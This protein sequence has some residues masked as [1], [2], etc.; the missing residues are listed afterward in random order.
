M[1]AERDVKEIG[2]RGSPYSH[3]DVVVVVVGECFFDGFACKTCNTLWQTANNADLFDTTKVTMTTNF[4][5]AQ[6]AP[7]SDNESEED[8]IP[9]VLIPM[10]ECMLKCNLR[11]LT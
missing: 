7:W 5:S 9:C 8:S 3:D 10:T 4:L 1:G 2:C 11:H 6:S